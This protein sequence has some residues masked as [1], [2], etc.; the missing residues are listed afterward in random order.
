MFKTYM[1][2]RLVKIMHFTDT[3]EER[4]ELQ[5]EYRGVDGDGKPIYLLKTRKGLSQISVGDYVALNIKGEAWI[6]DK[7][8]IDEM[9]VE[10]D[11]QLMERARQEEEEA[12]MEELYQHSVAESEEEE[13]INEQENG[14]VTNA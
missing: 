2:Y 12:Q 14:G 6:I 13:Y 3:E 1:S 10:V 4:R 7:E 5:L 9:Y 11:E 8:T